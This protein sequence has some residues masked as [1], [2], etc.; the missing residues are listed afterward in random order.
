[1]PPPPAPPAPTATDAY[2]S[3]LRS[4]QADAG[5][6]AVVGSPVV[7]GDIVGNSWIS[8]DDRADLSFPVSG[9]KGTAMVRVQSELQ[10]DSWTVSTLEVSGD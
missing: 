3:A 7:G 9:P 10:G 1:M 4:V 5:V 8:D 6:I 2:R